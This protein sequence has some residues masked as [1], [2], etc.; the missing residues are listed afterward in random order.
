[1]ETSFRGTSE[2]SLLPCATAAVR[3]VLVRSISRITSAPR[4]RRLA[5][6][7][8]FLRWVGAVED[9][10]DSGMASIAGSLTAGVFSAF[11]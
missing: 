5:R 1:M 2:L 7:P 4:R 10:I 11:S 6:A 8:N 3:A 9:V